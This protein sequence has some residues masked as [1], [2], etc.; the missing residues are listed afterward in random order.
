MISIARLEPILLIDLFLYERI[1]LRN[2]IGPLRTSPNRFKTWSGSLMAAI[3]ATGTMRIDCFPE[4]D[5]PNAREAIQ[6]CEGRENSKS[7]STKKVV[8]FFTPSDGA[9][10]SFV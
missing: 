8:K 3:H 9:S 2:Y 10:L 7:E 1:F 5:L 4:K 6:G